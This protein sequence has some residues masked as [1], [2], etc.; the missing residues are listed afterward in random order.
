MNEISSVPASCP[1]TAFE[2]YRAKG[3]T[4]ELRMMVLMVLAGRR[5]RS[6]LD[7]HL[8]PI[9][10]SSARLEALAAILNSPTPSS[11][12]D[13]AKRLRIEGPTMTRMLDT[14]PAT[15]WWNGVPPPATGVPS[16]WW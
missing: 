14:S 6:V 13:I 11:Q 12:S 1:P 2:V 10:Q 15:G 3:T 16:T 7:D 9:G 4:P 5:W 8:R